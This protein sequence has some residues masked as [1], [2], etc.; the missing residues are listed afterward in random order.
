MGVNP[1]TFDVPKVYLSGPDFNHPQAEQILND[2][3][4]ICER[5]GLEGVAI[6]DAKIDTSPIAR[7]KLDLPIYRLKQ[8][9]PGITI[10]YA[11]VELIASCD[12]LIANMDPFRGPSMDVGAAFEM[13]YMTAA[14]KPIVGY[15]SNR[16]SYSDRVASLYELMDQPVVERNG[17]AYTSDGW[18]VESFA[19]PDS[20]MVV[21]AALE[22]P[23]SIFP[24]FEEV[25]QWARR[26]TYEG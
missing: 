7:R 10:Y 19:L 9:N 22:G 26:L 24:E 14:G 25:V 21:G 12:V 4:M 5:Y 11:V 2:K 17:R 15:S 6:N 18:T 8:L 13:G 23:P 1:M 20:H 16:Q 3:K